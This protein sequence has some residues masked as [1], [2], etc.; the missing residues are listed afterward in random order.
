MWREAEDGQRV[1]YARGCRWLGSHFRG[2][3][4]VNLGVPGN[5]V[6]RFLARKRWTTVTEAMLYAVA[7]IN[8]FTGINATS[9]LYC[10]YIPLMRKRMEELLLN[11]GFPVAMR[12]VNTGVWGCSLLSLVYL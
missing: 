4:V 3:P 8:H 5:K 7:V 10:S 6:P 11:Q 1:P 12:C 2:A 9:F